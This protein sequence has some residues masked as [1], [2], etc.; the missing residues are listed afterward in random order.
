M[1]REYLQYF[2]SFTIGLAIVAS[3][4][5]LARYRQLPASLRY[6]TLLA[7]FDTS[8]ELT[9]KFLHDV[10][11]L[12]SNLF[13]FPFISIGELALLGLA[14][15]QALQSAAFN[16]VLPWLLGLFTAYA[17]AVSFSQFGMVRYAVGV[18]TIV[19]LLMLGLAGFYFRKL[20]N[21]LQVEHLLHDPFF[22]VS[23][24]L[25]VY[26]LGNLLIYLSSNYLLAHCSEQLQMIIFWGVRNLFNV[27][28]YLS[29][30]V[31]L[32]ISPTQERVVPAAASTSPRI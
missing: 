31:A 5:G 4:I 24:G 2:I 10:V 14:Y 15:R 18:A 7:C 6:I 23:I 11:K 20:L 3:L 29:Y 25:T 8:M 1:L 32:W 17:L 22:L 26:G 19:N 12:K 28:L 16:R 21:D 30:C 27:V 9:V 13:M